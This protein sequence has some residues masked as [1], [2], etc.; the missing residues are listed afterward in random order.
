MTV[1][2]TVVAM[3]LISRRQLQHK[4][5]TYRDAVGGEGEEALVTEQGPGLDLQRVK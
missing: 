5:D 4:T 1:I 3:T 2:L